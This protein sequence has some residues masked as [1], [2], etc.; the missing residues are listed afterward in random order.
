MPTV[1]QLLCYA[2]QLMMIKNIFPDLKM[3]VRCIHCTRVMTEVWSGCYGTR[4][5]AD[6]LR[7]GRTLMQEGLQRKT[8]F[9][10][11]CLESSEF[12]MCMKRT[13]SHE[14][15]KQY[16][17]GHGNKRGPSE[18]KK[19]EEILRVQGMRWISEVERTKT[20]KVE[21]PPHSGS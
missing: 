14:R 11:A 1:C 15:R 13:V 5:K 10:K 21:R 9:T 20:R 3:Q 2:L 18:F 8:R 6:Q 4:N 19:P 17:R 12:S 16:G 7:E